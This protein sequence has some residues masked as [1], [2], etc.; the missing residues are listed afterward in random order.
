MLV[1]HF[2]WIRCDHEG[3]HKGCPYVGSGRWELPVEVN[4]Q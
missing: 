1:F 2:L 3:T 4:G